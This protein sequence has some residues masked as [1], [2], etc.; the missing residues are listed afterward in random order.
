[1]FPSLKLISPTIVLMAGLQG[2]GKTT[3]AAKLALHLQIAAA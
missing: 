1:M 2:T 3:A